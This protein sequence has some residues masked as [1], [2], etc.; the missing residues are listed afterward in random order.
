MFTVPL[1]LG[2]ST[3]LLLLHIFFSVSFH[4]C[5][6]FLLHHHFLPKTDLC[7][8][9]REKK[10]KGIWKWKSNRR[11]QHLFLSFC[12]NGIVNQ[13]AR[14]IY[15]YPLPSCCLCRQ[16]RGG[17]FGGHAC[18]GCGTKY[19]C[20]NGVVGN[21]GDRSIAVV[22]FHGGANEQEGVRRRMRRGL[23][24]AHDTCLNLYIRAAVST[25][26]L[27]RGSDESG[28]VGPPTPYSCGYAIINGS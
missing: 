16:V 13:K 22:L 15:A 21:G 5:H 28:F 14:R 4:V 25:D 27:A 1:A 10:Q 12:T 19:R 24:L 7:S 26:S 9:L 11:I 8:H 6:L 18:V 3:R 17:A 2:Y 20:E 23:D